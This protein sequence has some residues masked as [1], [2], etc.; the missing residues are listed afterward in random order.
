ME[1]GAG[2]RLSQQGGH[3]TQKPTQVCLSTVRQ[4]MGTVALGVFQ[5]GVLV[6]DGGGDSREAEEGTRRKCLGLALGQM[7][8]RQA[9]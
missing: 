5:V 1:V 3:D 6:H 2:G 9:H 7:E 4:A 8:R